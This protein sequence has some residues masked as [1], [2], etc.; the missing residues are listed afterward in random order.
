MSKMKRQQG[1]FYTEG[2]KASPWQPGK[3]LNSKHLL[4]VLAYVL[5]RSIEAAMITGC[6][7]VDFQSAK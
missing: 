3:T 7:S 1:N 4:N 5:Q 6:L 2:K